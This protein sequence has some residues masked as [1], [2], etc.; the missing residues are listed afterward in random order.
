MVVQEYSDDY[1][2]MDVCVYKLMEKAGD[3]GSR[4]TAEVQFTL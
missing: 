1:H 2:Y 3:G 4:V